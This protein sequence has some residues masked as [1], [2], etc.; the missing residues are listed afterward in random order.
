[1]YL[2]LSIIYFYHSVIVTLQHHFYHSVFNNNYEKTRTEAFKKKQ[3]EKSKRSDI[4]F[5][6]TIDFLTE[7]FK[8]VQ[9]L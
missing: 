8:T 6:F 7:L 2:Y 5:F 3:S 1:M 4:T 9:I